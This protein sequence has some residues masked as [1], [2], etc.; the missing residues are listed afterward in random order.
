MLE[1]ND[2]L[3]TAEQLAAML[4]ISTH[5]VHVRRH[6]GQLPAAVRTGRRLL[7]RRSTVAAWLEDIEASD[8]AR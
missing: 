7:W 8:G 5:A 2:E 3:M 6:R 4:H 1:L